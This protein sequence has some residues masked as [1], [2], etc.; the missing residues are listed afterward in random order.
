[1]AERV[2]LARPY[3]KAA[4]QYAQERKQ[5]AAWSQVLQIAASVVSD[6]RVQK[7]LVS[8]LVTP[9]QLVELLADIAGSNLGKLDEQSRNFL[10]TLAHNRRLG[11][12]PEIAAVYERLRAQVEN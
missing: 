7:L 3:A 10:E 4:F 8:P 1:M 12:L 11:L 2:T 5:F 6:V 9:A